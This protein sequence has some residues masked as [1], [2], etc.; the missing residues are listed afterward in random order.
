ME[1]ICGLGALTWHVGKT[2]R[3]ARIAAEESNQDGWEYMEVGSVVDAS[4]ML[5]FLENPNE[6]TL[7]GGVVGFLTNSA[8]RAIYKR[9]VKM[10]IDTLPPEL[11]N[12]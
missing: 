8:A 3:N 9:S 12:V 4:P 7:I 11:W 5:G 1:L 6:G 2:L 10:G